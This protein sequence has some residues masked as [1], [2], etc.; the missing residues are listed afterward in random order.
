MMGLFHQAVGLKYCR[1]GQRPS[2]KEH[3]SP[4]APYGAEYFLDL[5]KNPEKNISKNFVNSKI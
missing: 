5:Y 2:R 4:Q 3:N 1:D